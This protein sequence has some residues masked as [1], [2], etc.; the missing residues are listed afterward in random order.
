MLALV[1][2]WPDSPVPPEIVVL[3]EQR[4]AA[5]EARDWRSADA[6]RQRIETAGFRIVDDGLAFTL[7]AARPPDVNEAGMTFHGTPESVPSRL[8]EPESRTASVVVLVDPA[9]SRSGRSSPR[10]M[11]WPMSR[12]CW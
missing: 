5:R 6:L 7:A 9:E 4:A 10:T 11:A 8:E 2:G 3:A 12:S 1:P